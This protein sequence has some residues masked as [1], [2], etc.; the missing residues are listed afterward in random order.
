[1]RNTAFRYDSVKTPDMGHALI[2]LIAERNITSVGWSGSFSFSTELEYMNEHTYYDLTK[3]GDIDPTTGDPKNL[4]SWVKASEVMPSWID[5]NTR[6]LALVAEYDEY[7]GKRQRQ[8]PTIQNQLDLLYKDIDSGYLGE[9]A[10]SS[11]FYNVIKDIKTK[12]Q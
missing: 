9:S 7:E 8:Y 10:K 3:S 1:M 6:Y 4:I 11:Q 12:N 2:E 5:L